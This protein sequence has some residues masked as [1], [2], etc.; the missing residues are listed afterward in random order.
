MSVSREEILEI[1]RKEGKVEYAHVLSGAISLD[2][3]KEHIRNLVPGRSPMNFLIVDMDM[4]INGDL[5]AFFWQT[6]IS[7]SKDG[8]SEYETQLLYRRFEKGNWE[9]YFPCIFLGDCEQVI[10][11]LDYALAGDIDKF[12]GDEWQDYYDYVFYTEKNDAETYVDD[13]SRLSLG[14]D[15]EKIC[16]YFDKVKY[17]C[18][19]RYPYHKYHE[20]KK[21]HVVLDNYGKY[22]W[23]FARNIH[24]PDIACGILEELAYDG[25]SKLEL[26]KSRVQSYLADIYMSKGDFRGAYALYDTAM[27]NGDVHALIK[28][29]EMYKYGLY[30]DKDY[31][32]YKRLILHADD[33][34]QGHFGADA[35]RW[36]WDGPRLC[37]YRELWQ[38]WTGVVEIYFADGKIQET[39]QR[40][41]DYRKRLLG[42]KDDVFDVARRINDVYYKVEPPENI[43]LCVWDAE[44][45]LKNNGYVELVFNEETYVFEQKSDRGMKQV[46]CNG[47]AYRDFREAL[48]NAEQGKLFENKEEIEVRGQRQ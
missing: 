45:L 24:K 38:I 28:I 27:K 34:V 32:K 17:V 9:P 6:A 41:A 15:K 20:T 23:E 25:S 8:E 5:Y 31:D 37:V 48:L 10:E 11:N 12:K 7:K 4:H 46:L 44:R 2:D 30:L 3:V 26:D 13:V 22:V 42:V 14:V 29:A 36:W 21:T 19:F 43:D 47:E 18:D 16:D 1:M 39:K 33:N 40:C 35:V